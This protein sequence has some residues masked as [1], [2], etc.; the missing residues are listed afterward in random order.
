MTNRLLL[1]SGK[2][3]SFSYS[4][5]RRLVSLDQSTYEKN[6][7]LKSYFK[8]T[9]LEYRLGI[10]FQSLPTYRHFGREARFSEQDDR[11]SR[12]MNGG[13]QTMLHWIIDLRTDWLKDIADELSRETGLPSIVHLWSFICILFFP[14]YEL[15]NLQGQVPSSGMFVQFLVL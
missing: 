3:E 2:K 8:E 10:I 11:V 6:G 1:F 4:A 7:L 15:E 9:A 5:W 14:T 12:T 13:E